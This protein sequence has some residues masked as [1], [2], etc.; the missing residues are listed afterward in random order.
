MI[1]PHVHLRDWNLAVK[2]TLAHGLLTAAR[3]GF[4]HLFD[5]P[6]TS[7]PLTSRK[8]IGR[9]LAEAE[10]ICR[11]LEE[12][13]GLVIRYSLYAGLTGSMEQ[14][15]EAAEAAVEL[16]PEVIGLKLFAGHSTGNMGLINVEERDSVF[17]TLVGC[18]YEGVV[19]VHCEKQERIRQAKL[20]SNSNG[21]GNLLLDHFHNRPPEAEFVSVEEQIQL[22]AKAGFQGTLHLCHISNPASIDCIEQYRRTVPFQ[23]SCGVTPHHL[24]LDTDTPDPDR[25][26]RVNPPVRTPA[27]REKLFSALLS[28]RIDW[29]ESDHAPHELK[30][31]AAGASGIP[32]FSG[33]LLLVELLRRAGLPEERIAELT[34]GRVETVYNLPQG[35]AVLPDRDEFYT[36][37]SSAADEYQADPYKKFYAGLTA[38]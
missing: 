8:T 4:T 30:A 16:F 10:E 14:V 34:S 32:G 37:F 11:K 3:A 22:A 33:F 6:N 26:M 13:E 29:I 1:D 31:K 2:D 15:R 21:T 5:M 38:H 35:I 28:G 20:I 19:A 18:G 36:Q 9:R 7:P 12:Q 27:M 23:L 24:L 17:K 25:L